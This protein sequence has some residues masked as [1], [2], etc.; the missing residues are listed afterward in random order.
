M[1]LNRGNL[2]SPKQLH[3]PSPPKSAIGIGDFDVV[4]SGNRELPPSRRQQLEGL[5][6]EWALLLNGA[7]LFTHERVVPVNL[8]GKSRPALGDISKHRRLG[9]TLRRFHQ[10]EAFC[11]LILAM[12]CAI[13]HS[14]VQAIRFKKPTPDRHIYSRQVA[15]GFPL[16]ATANTLVR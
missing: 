5:P 6:T 4:Y 16:V 8:A 11:R 14:R 7:G 15:P 10:A 9:R 12:L 3:G 1:V 2:L 13:H